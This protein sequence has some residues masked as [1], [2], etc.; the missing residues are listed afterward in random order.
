L[1]QKAVWSSKRAGGG[2]AVCYDKGNQEIE[3]IKEKVQKGG[4]TKR[5]ESASVSGSIS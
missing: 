4:Q 3:T 2:V 5:A 1:K